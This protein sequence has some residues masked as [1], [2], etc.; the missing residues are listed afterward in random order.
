[1]AVG[2]EAG[3]NGDA[4]AVTV[5]NSGHIATTGLD[6]TAIFAQSIGG[7]GGQAQ[8]FARTTD[9]AG[10]ASISILGNLGLGGAGGATGDGGT[11]KVTNSGGI[12]TSGDESHGIFA[13]SIGGGGGVAGDV[14]RALKNTTLPVL[15]TINLDFGIG[16]EFARDGGCVGNGG[17]VTVSNTG[18]IITHG[19]GSH[20]I[21]AQS[22]GGGGG[23][24]GSIGNGLGF[25]GSVGG[26]GSAGAVSITQTGDITTTG[27]ASHG[28]V[29]QSAGGSG[30]GGTVTIGLDGHI[31]ATGVGSY[32]ILAQSVGTTGQGNIA[33][34][35]SAGGLVNGGTQG[36]VGVV[37]VDG[38][39]N[40]LT[41]HGTITTAD[42]LDGTAIVST[43][44][45]VTIDNYGTIIGSIHLGVVNEAFGVP[46]AEVAYPTGGGPVSAL[47]N[48]VGHD[49]QSGD[50]VNLGGGGILTNSGTMSPR[51]LGVVASTALT[52]NLVQTST[53]TFNVDLDVQT[54]LADQIGGTG[55]AGL[56]GTVTTNVLNP[57][58]ALPGA[59]DNILVSATGGVTNDGL[60]LQHAPSAVITYDLIWN[61]TDL[62]LATNIDF[63]PVGLSHNETAVGG[64]FNAIQLAGGNATLAPTVAELFN[65]PD[66]PSLAAAYDSLSPASYDTTTQATLDMDQLAVRAL[67][68]HMYRVR[69]DM[70]ACQSVSSPAT[71]QAANRDTGGVR[72]ASRDLRGLDLAGRARADGGGASGSRRLLLA[73]TGAGAAGDA[74][75][76]DRGS[77]LMPREQGWS[78]R[79]GQ[80]GS[81]DASADLPGF[82]YSGW[83]TA[84]GYDN[85][86]SRNVVLGAAWV[87][88]L[89]KTALDANVGAGRVD[90]KS[91]AVYGTYLGRKYYFEGVLTHGS[92]QFTN[93]RNTVV[94][95]LLNHASSRHDGRSFT[96][97]AAAGWYTKTGLCDLEPFAA[98]YYST[99]Q[100]DA[101]TEVEAGAV[102]LHVQARNTRTMT[103]EL[104][105]RASR[106][107]DRKC[108]VWA[109]EMSIAWSH[110]FG[111]DGH[112]LTSSFIGAPNFPFTITG[113][114]NGERLVVGSGL[115]V[116]GK[117]GW[118]VEGKYYGQLRGGYRTHGGT[119]ALNWRF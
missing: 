65:L 111:S 12:E 103:S 72:V 78:A 73:S 4:G 28:I 22:I 17:Q 92:H 29:A 42:G 16:S 84:M 95:S 31:N 76:A 63:A 108:G 18:N 96:A 102:G 19:E 114:E 34:T 10:S 2:G 37:F 38:N 7:G 85:R 83:D 1:M 67:Q 86:V 93:D 82:G 119:V 112:R 106:V 24:G 104:G 77:W 41:N 51:G 26:T 69:A 14:A 61:P 44:G 25:A 75:A 47:T 52:G 110:D 50:I 27:A 48:E 118:S 21:F 54:R 56:D 13:Q 64:A 20:G 57:G 68:H 35:I 105:L 55:T 46:L 11:V 59:R 101:F 81:Q 9:T 107:V 71:Q 45:V 39:H 94:G 70:R 58:W 88:G 87:T 40:T 115:T 23:A 43:P 62:T 117:S 49:F 90:S 60:Q 33:V 15:G 89:T 53:G 80:H 3:A 98:A 32:G 5:T 99:L 36:G 116:T 6:A 113:R 30:S 79:F 66:L 74:D 91:G 97:S 109:P 100:E 8:E